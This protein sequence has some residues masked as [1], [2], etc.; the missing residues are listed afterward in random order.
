MEALYQKLTRTSY[1]LLSAVLVFESVGCGTLMY[2][3]RKG[4]R[5]GHIDAGVAVLDGIGLLFFLIPGVIAYAVDFN[6]G[7]IYLPGTSRSS[8]QLKDIKQVRFDP[9][10]GSSGTIARIIKEETGYE[11]GQAESRM[12]VVHLKTTDDMLK[13]FAQVL[14]EIQDSRLSQLR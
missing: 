12:K 7:T 6:N 13:E 10:H 1:L 2:P 11:L 4:Q 5:S 8:L 9:G 3:E 14:P